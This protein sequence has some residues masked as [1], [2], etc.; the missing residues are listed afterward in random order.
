[1]WLL[2]PTCCTLRHV[3]V[4]LELERAHI[5]GR[6]VLAWTRQWLLLERDFPKD[7]TG[8]WRHGVVEW[9]YRC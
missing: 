5:H 2:L 6:W 3:P 8:K 7:G 4:A 9:R 1:L